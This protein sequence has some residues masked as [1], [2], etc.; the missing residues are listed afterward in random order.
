M[1]FVLAEDANNQPK[2]KF[3][4]NLYEIGE[5]IRVKQ[6]EVCLE[7]SCLVPPE[8]T[9]KHKLCPVAPSNCTTFY[10]E[11]ECCP[12][13]KCQEL[14]ALEEESKLINILD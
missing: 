12:A 9:C 10:I 2:C 4:G 7:C 13:I 6:H 1:F 5:K 3:G 8:I 14:E 11:G